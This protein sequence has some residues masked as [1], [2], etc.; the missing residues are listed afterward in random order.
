MRF[1]EIRKGLEGV[2]FNTLR[3]DTDNYFEGVLIKEE[4]VK[5]TGILDKFFGAPA[6]PSHN[7]LSP[8][9]QKII[10]SFGGVMSGQALYFWNQGNDAIFAMLWPWQDGLHT[11][12]KIVQK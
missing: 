7:K 8:Q 6:L 11:T 12:V 9:I 4:L 1:S 2:V 10:D 3:A 5:L